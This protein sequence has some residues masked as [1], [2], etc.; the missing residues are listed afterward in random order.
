[1]DA[2][3]LRSRAGLGSSDDGTHGA[4]QLVAVPEARIASRRPSRRAGSAAGRAGAGSAFPTFLIVSGVWERIFPLLSLAV[5]VSHEFLTD[6][7]EKGRQR[8]AA[9]SQGEAP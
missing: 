8:L 9:P 4:R 6:R 5:S 2:R 7:H 1:M 3:S